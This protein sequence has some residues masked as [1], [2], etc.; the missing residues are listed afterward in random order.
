[1]HDFRGCQRGVAL[2]MQVGGRCQPMDGER[3][4]GGDGCQQGGRHAATL[5]DGLTR[6]RALCV[7]ILCRCYHASP[8]G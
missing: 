8:I 4:R 6:L 3:M 1:M 5:Y 7:A 2:Q